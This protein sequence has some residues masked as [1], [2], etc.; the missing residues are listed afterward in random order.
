MKL[1]GFKNRKSD[2]SAEAQEN[3]KSSFCDH[4]SE[5][6]KQL[7]SSFEFSNADNTVWLSIKC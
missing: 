7:I 6:L 1:L 4:K 3:N 2:R 5:G